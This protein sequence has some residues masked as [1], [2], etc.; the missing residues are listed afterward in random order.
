MMA[1]LAIVIFV[2]L[3]LLVH[4]LIQW[5]ERRDMRAA[6]REARQSPLWQQGPPP[7]RP[8]RPPQP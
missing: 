8:P 5:T 2:A 1:L 7:P 3:A 6:V 4:L